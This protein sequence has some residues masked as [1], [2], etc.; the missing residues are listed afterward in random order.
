MIQLRVDINGEIK[1]ALGTPNL[2]VLLDKVED[3]D[4]IVILNN[5]TYS[6][7]EIIALPT[8]NYDFETNQVVD[9]PVLEPEE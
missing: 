8:K 3:T 9:R 2:D 1:N 5:V 6:T 7:D 4:Q